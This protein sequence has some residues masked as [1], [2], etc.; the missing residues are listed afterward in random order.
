MA[1]EVLAVDID[2]VL[3]PFV[4]EFIQHHNSTYNTEHAVEE[5]LTYEFQHVIQQDFEETV[6]RIFEVTSRECLHVEPI[7]DSIEAI[8]SLGERYDL[9]V[10][11]ARSPDHE[12]PIRVWLEKHY[13]DSFGGI[14]FIGHPGYMER[15]K[16]KA[17][18]C[19]E[20]GAIALIDDS[21]SHIELCQAKEIKGILFGDYPWN[22]LNG[23]NGHSE[24]VRCRNWQEVLEHFNG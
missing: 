8:R 6:R 1:K 16:P 19:E 22:Q 7:D 11:T 24:I 15:Y 18:V 10:I 5:F 3:F 23:N 13:G 2:E 21:V 9:E 20:L 4:E 17:E 14:N 12:E